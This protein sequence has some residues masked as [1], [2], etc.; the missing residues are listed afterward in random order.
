[1][2]AKKHFR[3]PYAAAPNMTALATQISRPRR[4]IECMPRRKNIS[5]G[6]RRIRPGRN[7]K[8]AEGRIY[9]GPKR[10]TTFK[11][12]GTVNPKPAPRKSHV[13]LDI[14]RRSEPLFLL[15]MV[16]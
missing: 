15:G 9:E 7:S 14:C 13:L 16:N 8:W 12:I 6:K 2:S 1:M 5:V 11:N 4:G 3:K 10:W